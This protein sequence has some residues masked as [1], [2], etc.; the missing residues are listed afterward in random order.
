MRQATQSHQQVVRQREDVAPVG[1]ACP[2]GAGSDVGMARRDS[3]RNRPI[4]PGRV[5]DPARAARRPQPRRTPAFVRLGA[6]RSDGF[7]HDGEPVDSLRDAARQAGSRVH[8][9]N[10]RRALPEANRSSDH[11][12]NGK[13]V[14]CVP[15]LGGD[16]APK[17]RGA[18][19]IRGASTRD[20]G[21]RQQQ[22]HKCSHEGSEVPAVLSRRPLEHLGD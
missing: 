3:D 11:T 21:N 19:I 16:R 12:R 13:Q 18:G 1:Y 10:G 14:R 4:E 20:G 2:D 9:D 15:L 8:L 5:V 6:N 7:D 22:E 17:F